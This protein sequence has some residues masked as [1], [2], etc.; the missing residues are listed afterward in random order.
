VSFVHGKNTYLSIDD[1]DISPYCKTSDIERSS[2]KTDTTV[3]GKD[4]HCYQ[5]GLL[6]SKFSVEGLYDSS[7]DTGPAAVL[8]P[9][10]G[11]VVQLIRRREGIGAG[12]PQEIVDVLIEKYTE[13]SPCDE[14]IKWKVELQGSDDIDDTPQ[15][16]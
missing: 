2:D 10:I 6:D 5:G 8:T 15:D 4:S 11:E 12:L 7:I 9:L 3:Y 14:Y 1:N 13:T 16:S